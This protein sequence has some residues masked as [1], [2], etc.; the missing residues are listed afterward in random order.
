MRFVFS[1][2][3]RTPTKPTDQ[4]CESAH[5]T[6][7]SALEAKRCTNKE[8][9]LCSSLLHYAQHLQS[10]SFNPPLV[11]HFTWCPPV[12]IG[13]QPCDTTADWYFPSGPSW[14]YTQKPLRLAKQLMNITEPWL[15]LLH[16]LS[17]FSRWT[18][19][20]SWFERF[21]LCSSGKANNIPD[22]TDTFLMAPWTSPLQKNT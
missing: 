19:L 12:R 9:Q 13:T 7:C 22:R 3:T 10:P 8:F 21:R 15:M 20:C 2:G 16:V 11:H 5:S 17:G 6:F 1:P 14:F 18:V 4:D